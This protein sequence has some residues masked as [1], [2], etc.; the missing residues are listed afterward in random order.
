[1]ALQTLQS[2][3]LLLQLFKN[4]SKSSCYVIPLSGEYFRNCAGLTFYWK[5]YSIS[6]IM[7]PFSNKF[8][9]SP[10][11]KKSHKKLIIK[12]TL[13][14]EERVGRIT[15]CCLLVLEGAMFYKESALGPSASKLNPV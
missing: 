6:L 2:H 14:C 1:M 10:Y 13:S 9:F 5:E 4:T 8:P 3:L 15:S 7:F 12:I 11:N